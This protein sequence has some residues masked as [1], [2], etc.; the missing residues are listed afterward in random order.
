MQSFPLIRLSHIQITYLGGPDLS[1]WA[2]VDRTE[3]SQRLLVH[4]CKRFC[5]YGSLSGLQYLWPWRG[6]KA[7]ESLFEYDRNEMNIFTVFKPLTLGERH[8][9]SAVVLS[10]ERKVECAG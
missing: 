8:V 2:T 6:Y 9:Q 10:R 5:P 3:Y 4:L 1:S 7:R